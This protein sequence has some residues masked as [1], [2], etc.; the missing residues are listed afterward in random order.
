MFGQL[1]K[2]RKAN[3]EKKA[4]VTSPLTNPP[5][6][7]INKKTKVEKALATKI[8]ARASLSRLAKSQI[9]NSGTGLN[10]KYRKSFGNSKRAT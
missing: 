1:A 3:K 4:K 6:E 7:K 9:T 5:K 10:N 8:L 2:L